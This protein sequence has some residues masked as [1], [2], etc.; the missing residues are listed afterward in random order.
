M[1]I[2][3]STSPWPFSACC[4]HRV[5]ANCRNRHTPI[6][7]HALVTRHNIEV[8]TLDPNGAM[9]VGTRQLRLQLRRH[10]PP[11]LPR[12][13]RPNHA[14]RHPQRLGLAH[15][16][17]NPQSATHLDKFKM[18]IDPEIQPPV[19]LP[20]PPA[21]ATPP[22]DAAYLP[23]RESTAL[24]GLGRH[25]PGNDQIR[26]LQSRHHRPHRHRRAPRSSGPASSPAVSP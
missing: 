8:H 3:P 5:C 11:I 23:R 20:R 9:A 6:D 26:R 18:T 7:R 19:R 4:H 12:L 10:R 16:F 15:A 1:R 13:L 22:P 17:P 21:P 14:H 24:H 25:R 2:Q